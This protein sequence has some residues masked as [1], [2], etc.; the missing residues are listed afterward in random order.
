MADYLAKMGYPPQQV[1]MMKSHI[2]TPSFL[3]CGLWLVAA[4]AYLLY[5]RRFFIQRAAAADNR[6]HES[7]N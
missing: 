7:T 3:T 6:V 1:E 4:L 5:T 2:P